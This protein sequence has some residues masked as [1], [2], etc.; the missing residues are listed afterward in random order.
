M[1]GICH[2]RAFIAVFGS[3]LRCM[4]W[5]RLIGDDV[6]VVGHDLLLDQKFVYGLWLGP[7]ITEG[8]ARKSSL[9]PDSRRPR[10]YLVRRPEPDG[11]R[12]GS[13]ANKRRT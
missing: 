9:R 7:R 10:F 1:K 3:E 4:N 11:H 2:F 6:F 12:S 13:E 8:R 5:R